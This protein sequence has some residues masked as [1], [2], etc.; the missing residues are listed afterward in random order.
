MSGSGRALFGI[1]NDK[2]E[3]VSTLFPDCQTYIVRL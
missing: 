3:S 1:F 2:P